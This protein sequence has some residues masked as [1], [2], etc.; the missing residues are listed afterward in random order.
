MN[1]TNTFWFGILGVLFFIVPSVLGG[2]QFENYS[3]IQ[4]F[5][6]ESYAIDTPYGIYLRLFG[7]LPSG[8]FI[9]LFSMS[10]I[11]FLPKS[12]LL[13]IGLT[14]FA[15]FYG[16]GNIIV[17]VFPCDAG[18]NKELI[19]PSI[20]HIIHIFSGAITYTFVPF[21]LFLIG[22]SA[23]KWNNGKR[24]VILSVLCGAVAFLLSMLLSI[25]PTGQ[26]IG[27]IQRGIEMS[28]LLWVTVFVFYIK[29]QK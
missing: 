24:M 5:I 20:S 2:F 19:N 11:K 1:K 21:C 29:K 25:N 9:I 4:Q 7:F 14:G 8:V 12:N 6:S 15:F 27:L 16:L 17:S 26:F 18:C 23:N 13:K 28:I 22:V 3:H 10:A